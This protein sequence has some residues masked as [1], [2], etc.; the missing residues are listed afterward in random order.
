MTLYERAEK[1]KTQG[2]F[3]LRSCWECNSSHEY[4]KK[5]DGLFNCFECQRWFMNGDFFSNE[6]HCES[7]Y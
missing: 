6:K 2:K 1:L 5:A 7:L 4:L 3:A